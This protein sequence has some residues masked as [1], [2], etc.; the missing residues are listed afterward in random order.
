MYVYGHA[1]GSDAF[2]NGLIIPMDSVLEDVKQQ[3]DATD[4]TAVSLVGPASL[5]YLADTA[6]HGILTTQPHPP[7]T[8][9]GP[10]IFDSLDFDSILDQMKPDQE[11]QK[12]QEFSGIHTTSLPDFTTSRLEA[13]STSSII[14]DPR[15]LYSS[16]SQFFHSGEDARSDW[17]SSLAFGSASDPLCRT[18]RGSPWSLINPSSR[19]IH[20]GS[21]SSSRGSKDPLRRVT[22]ESACDSSGSSYEN[23]TSLNANWGGSHGMLSNVSFGSVAPS[24]DSGYASAMTSHDGSPAKND[25]L[26]KAPSQT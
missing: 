23:S 9:T 21:S 11:H 3:L 16:P 12:D 15:L 7:S 14:N 10:D 20:S 6:L 22:V 25:D 8:E 5:M 18:E 24:R 17:R 2:G 19:T 4:A 1:V 26:P 13:N